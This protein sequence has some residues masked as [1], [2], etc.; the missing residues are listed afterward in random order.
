MAALFSH[1]TVIINSVAGPGVD[2]TLATRLIAPTIAVISPETAAKLHSSTTA[3][4]T[5]TLS[6]LAHSLE[7]RILTA[8]RLP[9]DTLLT[10]INAPKRA[11]VGTSPGKLRLLFVSERAGLNTP[12]LSSED[13]SDLRIYTKARVIYALTAAKVAGAVTQTNMYDYRRG[14]TPSNKHSHFGV[15][16]SCLEIKLKDNGPHKTTDEQNAGQ[17]VVT[18]ASVAGGET[19]LGVNGTLCDAL[20]R[21]STNKIQER[22]GTTTRWLIFESVFEQA[23]DRAV[24]SNDTTLRVLVH[25]SRRSVIRLGDSIDMKAANYVSNEDI[26]ALTWVLVATTHLA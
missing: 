26:R 4:V 12:P 23:L 22:S 21:Y 5:G 20:A 3:T 18:G 16:L 17:V 8:G 7:T 6:G 2:L 24:N 13:L 15:P 11:T 9:T 1:A 10:R 19:A 14:L 25:P